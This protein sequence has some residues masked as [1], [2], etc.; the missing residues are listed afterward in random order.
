MQEKMQPKDEFELVIEPLEERIAP[1]KGHG[2]NNGFGNGGA[3]GT[4]NG[5]EDTDR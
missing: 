3:D 2:G 1:V 5:F 4:P